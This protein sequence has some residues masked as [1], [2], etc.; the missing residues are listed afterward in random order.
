MLFSAFVLLVTFVQVDVYALT[1]ATKRGG[2]PVV[3]LDYATFEGA[4]TG[5]VDSF[6]GISYAQPPLGNLRF[7]HPEPPLPLP[8]TTL[9]SDFV[10]FALFCGN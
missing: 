3:N 10:L 7:R 5:W 1:I 8:G 6:L 4:S 2:G 9:V